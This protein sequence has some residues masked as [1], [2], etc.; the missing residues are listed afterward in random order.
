MIACLEKGVEIKNEPNVEK[1]L[2]NPKISEESKKLLP[3]ML[4][5]RKTRQK[6]LENPSNEVKPSTPEATPVSTSNPVLQAVADRR[7]NMH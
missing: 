7:L 4:N 3:I 1:L 5:K 6:P 2:N